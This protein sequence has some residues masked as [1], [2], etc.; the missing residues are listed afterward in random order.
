MKHATPF[1][2]GTDSKWDKDHVSVE[3]EPMI[4]LLETKLESESTMPALWSLSFSFLFKCFAMAELVVAAV[5]LD[6]ERWLL[7]GVMVISKPISVNG[8]GVWS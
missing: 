7:E 2:Q 4:S 5:G 3:R 8:Q 1:A 6:E